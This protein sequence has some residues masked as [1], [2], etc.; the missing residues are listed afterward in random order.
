MRLDVALGPLPDDEYRAERLLRDLLGKNLA[1]L[2]SGVARN[3]LILDPDH[4]ILRIQRTE[5]AAGNDEETFA[6][7]VEDFANAA[8]GWLEQV[9]LEAAPAAPG[10]ALRL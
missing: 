6:A 3:V 4:G 9:A 1:A 7:A 5:K 10:F 8:E 2:G